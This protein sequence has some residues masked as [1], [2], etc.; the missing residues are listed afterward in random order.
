MTRHRVTI[1]LRKLAG[2]RHGAYDL[3]QFALIL[4]VF[5]VILYGSFEIYK[6]ISI[7]QSLSAGTY[8]AARYLSVYHKYYYDLRY[9][10]TGADDTARAEQLVWQSLRANGFISDSTPLQ[11]AIRY[12][13]GAGRPIS[14]PVDFPH[15]NEC[16]G[17]YLAVKDANIT[18]QMVYT[19]LKSAQAAGAQAVTTN[20]PLCQFNLDKQQAEMQKLHAGYRSIPVFYFSQLM[21]LALGLDVGNYGWERHYIDARPLLNERGLWNGA[22]DG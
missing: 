15:K 21:G 10:R 12:S 9:N 1:R 3:I 19:I 17:A 7:R 6:L 18:R 13:D 20:C 8:Q 4:P 2:D 22:V 5:V 11:L 14:T 16:C